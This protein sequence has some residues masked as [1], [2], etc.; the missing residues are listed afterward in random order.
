MCSSD[1]MQKEFLL[2]FIRIPLILASASNDLH[3]LRLLRRFQNI[4]RQYVRNCLTHLL[5]AAAHTEA[6]LACVVEVKLDCQ[7]D[8]A[9]HCKRAG[10][11]ERRGPAYRPCGLH[12]PEARV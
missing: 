11:I 5:R 9:W 12:G 1:T 6:R 2:V 8:P 7:C 4:R 10:Q 3:L